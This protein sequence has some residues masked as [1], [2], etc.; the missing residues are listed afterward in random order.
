MVA[1]ASGSVAETEKRGEGRCFRP[2][3]T[4]RADAARDYIETLTSLD[5][6]EKS[7]LITSIIRGLDSVDNT[8]RKSVV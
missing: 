8:D 1:F 3:N 4:K 2:K 7:T 5:H 6:W